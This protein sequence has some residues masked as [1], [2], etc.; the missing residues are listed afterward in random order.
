MATFF[1]ILFTVVCKFRLWLIITVI[2][3]FLSVAFS[4]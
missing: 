3:I 2:F 4:D 1:S